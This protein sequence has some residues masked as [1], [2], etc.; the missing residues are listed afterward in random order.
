MYNL[1]HYLLPCHFLNNTLIYENP[2]QACFYNLSSLLLFFV[3]FASA[4]AISMLVWGADTTL[5]TFCFFDARDSRLSRQKAAEGRVI[6]MITT[7]NDQTPAMGDTKV[8]VSGPTNAP[9][10]FIMSKVVD[11]SIND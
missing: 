7:C 4:W 10:A 9:A 11:T 3:A 6:I 5:T 8:I 1:I 2:R